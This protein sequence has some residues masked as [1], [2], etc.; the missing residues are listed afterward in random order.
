MIGT[1]PTWWMTASGQADR[2]PSSNSPACSRPATSHSID[3]RCRQTRIGETGRT[4]GPCR[5]VS[6]IRETRAIFASSTL[7][8]LS[9]PRI[10]RFLG[11]GFRILGSLADEDLRKLYVEV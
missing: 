2:R 5:R 3:R 10:R 6:T 7:A 8:L 11:P 1:I 9:D 4:A